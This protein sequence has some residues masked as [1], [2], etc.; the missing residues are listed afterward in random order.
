MQ[1]RVAGLDEEA[2][3]ARVLHTDI[4]TR[5]E[6]TKGKIQRAQAQRPNPSSSASSRQSTG[7]GVD[8][9]LKAQLSGKK[10]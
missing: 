7:F 10:S 6:V 3:R 9:A 2:Q 5:I 1:A 4:L 8:E